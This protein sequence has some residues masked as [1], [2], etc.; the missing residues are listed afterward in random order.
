MKLRINAALSGTDCEESPLRDDWKRWLVP[1]RPTPPPQPMFPD[2]APDLNDWRDPKV[3]WGLVVPDNDA[4]SAADRSAGADLHPSLQALLADRAP[5]P[6]YRWR[7]DHDNPGNRLRAYRPDSSHFDLTLGGG[8]YGSGPKQ[9]PRYLLIAG[10][11]DEIPWRAQYTIGRSSMVGRIPLH[12]DE[13]ARYV[14][15]LI[16]GWDPIPLPVPAAVW[17]VDLGDPDITHWMR[18][19]V[20]KPIAKSLAADQDFALRY[21]NGKTEVASFERLLW[22]LEAQPALV[23]TTSHGMTGPLDDSDALVANLGIPQDQNLEAIDLDALSAAFAPRGCIWYG[24]ACCSAGSAGLSLYADLLKEGSQAAKITAAVAAA[25]SNIAPLPLA[26]LSATEPARAFVGHVEPTFDWTLRLPH[27]GQKMT[28][29]LIRALYESLF[30]PNQTIGHAFREVHR[31][32]LELHAEFNAAIDK[33]KAGDDQTE[34][35][36]ASALMARDWES[37]VILGDPTV[38]LRP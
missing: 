16:D 12:G 29:H 4:I 35:A 37:I 22:A 13:L 11:V 25:G 20:A 9:Q 28:Y 10:G 26:L 1:N 5:A 8:N 19:L 23:V 34:H 33:T 38:T 36:L 32:G 21:V 18:R 15:H 17:A 7:T 31:A 14:Q 6:L 27:N 2:Q 30:Q 3:G 24:H